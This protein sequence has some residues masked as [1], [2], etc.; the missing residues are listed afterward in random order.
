[1]KRNSFFPLS[2][3]KIILTI[4]CCK[5]NIFA[6]QN[7]NLCLRSLW[8]LEN[9]NFAASARWNL[10]IFWPW[11]SRSLNPL[12]LVDSSNT[13]KKLPLVTASS[14]TQVSK[15]PGA[16]PLRWQLTLTARSWQGYSVPWSILKQD[17]MYKS[18]LD[19]FV[20]YLEPSAVTEACLEAAQGLP[21][22]SVS[23]TPSRSSTSVL[24]S[25]TTLTTLEVGLDCQCGNRETLSTSPITPMV[26]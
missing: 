6:T 5:K 15:A 8:L 26:T 2:N 4:L 14:K 21:K 16:G 23:L 10:P 7:I 9:F 19:N 18:Y 11:R 22:G 12:V 25:H 13:T 20:D 3:S 1:M 17:S 24:R